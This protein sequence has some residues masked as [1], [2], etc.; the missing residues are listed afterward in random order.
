[1]VVHDKGGGGGSI[2][3]H[4]VYDSNKTLTGL[5]NVESQLREFSG[6]TDR[7]VSKFSN[8]FAD[9]SGESINSYREFIDIYMESANIAASHIQLLIELVRLADSEIL[10][11]D[12]KSAKTFQQT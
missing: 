3:A 9:L 7:I 6:S 2:S 12:K 8:I 1:M 5:T 10:E 11:A 4:I